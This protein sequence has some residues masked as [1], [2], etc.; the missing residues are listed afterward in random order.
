MR[1]RRVAGVVAMALACALLGSPALEAASPIS[2]Q[3]DGSVEIGGR[4][5]RCG[6]VRSTQFRPDAC[7]S[8]IPRC[9]NATPIPSVCSCSITSAATTMSAQASSV[10]IAGLRSVACERGGSTRMDW[11]RSASPLAMHRRPL[12]TPLRRSAVEGSTNASRRRAPPW[13]G[14]HPRRRAHQRSR[15]NRRSQPKKRLT[16]SLR[17]RWF[18]AALHASAWL[19]QVVL[20]LPAVMHAD[21]QIGSTPCARDTVMV[22]GIC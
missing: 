22:P 19:T 6:K 5:L 9:C 21:R 12:R 13:R 18:E 3:R 10:P 17:P 20:W 11:H 2:L 15:K 1:L 4:S 8:S 7:W 14:K 16:S